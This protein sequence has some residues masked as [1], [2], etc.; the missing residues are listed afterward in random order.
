[1]NISNPADKNGQKLLLFSSLLKA[2]SRLAPQLYFAWFQFL[3]RYRRT[4]LGPVWLLVGPA[5]FIALLGLLFSR[6]GGNDPAVFVPYLA[7]GLIVWTLITGFI[8]GSTTVFQRGRAQM[9]Q[10]SMSLNDIVMVDMFST[11]IIFLHQT[12]LIV[13]VFMFF[14]IGLSFYSLVSL[15]GLAFL[16][17]N[18]IWL[19]VFFGIIGARYRDLAEIV[20]AVMRI[21]FLATPIIWMPGPGAGGRA[22]VMGA[23]LVYNP[24]YHFLELVRAPLLGTPIAPLSWIVVISIT[25]AG[26][27]LA[28]FFYNR[29]AR[30]VP[31]WV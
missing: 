21:A 30:I 20:Q 24:F 4:M 6:I 29:F 14:G 23:F 13:A 19:S 8:T 31:L 12:I 7:I 1:M 15:I 18:G 10:G 9:L 16:I 5:L 2:H 3:I 17:A 28:H 11:V 22:G 26:F 27:V 25:V